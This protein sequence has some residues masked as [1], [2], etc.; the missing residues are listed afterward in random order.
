MRDL[1]DKTVRKRTPPTSETQ[2]QIT[3]EIAVLGKTT[4]SIDTR[5]F[6]RRCIVIHAAHR[7]GAILLRC[8]AAG[9]RR[10][11]QQTPIGSMPICDC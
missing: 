6:I 1:R 11:G 2:R 3:D 9:M 10:V 4:L 5:G 8:S 7:D